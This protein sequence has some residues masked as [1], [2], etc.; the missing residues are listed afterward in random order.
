[1]G[2]QLSKRCYVVHIL[3]TKELFFK[4]CDREVKRYRIYTAFFYVVVNMTLMI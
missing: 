2:P 3:V 1:M 4:E